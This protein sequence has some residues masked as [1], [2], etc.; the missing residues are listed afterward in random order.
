MN[1]WI[2]FGIFILSA[3]QSV[4]CQSVSN[5]EKATAKRTN[6]T[7]WKSGNY[8]GLQVGKSTY[9]DM[10]RVLGKPKWYGTPYTSR[11]VWYEYPNAGE[12]Q[13]KIVVIIS[14]RNKTM[15]SIDLYPENLSK[16]QVIEYFGPDYKV[17]K[18]D[19][20]PCLGDGESAPMYESL[21]GEITFIEYRNRG[22]AIGINYQGIVN[23]ISF[24]KGPI[25]SSRSKCQTN[26]LK[27]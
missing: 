23:Q 8:H 11:E 27:R 12:F 26:R 20:E 13:S 21:D 3:V 6:V 18:Y 9:A 10:I 19:L 5:G 2:L 24:V 14:K 1:A 16:N 4:D 25:G 7:E 17:T 15:S 22:I